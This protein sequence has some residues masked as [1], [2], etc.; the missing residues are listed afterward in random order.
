MRA[1]LTLSLPADM[2]ASL[3]RKAERAGTSVSNY[4]RQLL[5]HEKTIIRQ[6]DLLRACKEAE[7]EYRQG[8]TRVLRSFEDLAG[9][10]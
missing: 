9:D 7:K 3:K 1:I 4:V 10:L 2:L 6:K 8:G 5:D